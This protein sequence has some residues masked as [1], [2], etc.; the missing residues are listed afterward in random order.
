MILRSHDLKME[1]YR[2]KIM[3]EIE[4]NGLKECTFHPK[5]NKRSHILARK[6]LKKLQSIKDL[7]NRSRLKEQEYCHKKK[8]MS[9]EELLNYW[10]ESEQEVCTSKSKKISITEAKAQLKLLAEQAESSLNLIISKPNSVKSPT[11]IKR[12]HFLKRRASLLGAI[13]SK[14]SQAMLLSRLESKVSSLLINPII[15]N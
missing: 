8:E 15:H 11:K 13:S 12:A 3:R 4:E 10:V 6:S 5:T 7:K 9:I 14:K 1:S 2:K